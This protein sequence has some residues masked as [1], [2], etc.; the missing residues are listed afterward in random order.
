MACQRLY[1]CAAQRSNQVSQI[2]SVMWLETLF[3]LTLRKTIQGSG[4]QVQNSLFYLMENSNCFLMKK[5]VTCVPPIVAPEISSSAKKLFTVSVCVSNSKWS[6]RLD[7]TCIAKPIFWWY[8]MMLV[9]KTFFKG[10]QRILSRV[11]KNSLRQNENVYLW[12]PF[13]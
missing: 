6:H 1:S 4:I 10:P 8:K 9:L 11:R 7:L 5:S 12:R 13:S 3:S 2:C